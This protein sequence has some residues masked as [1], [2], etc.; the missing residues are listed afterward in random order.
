MFAFTGRPL[1]A[2]TDP[3]VMDAVVAQPTETAMLRI[4]IKAEASVQDPMID[5]ETEILA[6][7]SAE[8]QTAMAAM[9]GLVVSVVVDMAN[10]E[11]VATVKVSVT[12]VAIVMAHVVLTQQGEA[13]QIPMNQQIGVQAGQH[14]RDRL[15]LQTTTV[16]D[17]PILNQG[18][19]QFS[20]TIHQH[21]L[22]HHHTIRTNMIIKSISHP[23][24]VT[25]TTIHTIT[26]MISRRIHNPAIKVVVDHQWHLSRQRGG[27]NSTYRKGKCLLI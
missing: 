27:P 23:N 24:A 2:T 16:P 11:A 21:L 1:K 20:I 17:N 19:N 6:A 9:L 3:I 18:E 15:H 22:K 12:E 25:H 14:P 13:S 8:V 10:P 7:G 5:M 26:Q 4:A